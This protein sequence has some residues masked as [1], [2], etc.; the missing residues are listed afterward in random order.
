[1]RWDDPE[2][3][4]EW[5]EMDNYHVSDRDRVLPRLA[6]LDSPFHYAHGVA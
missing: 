5:P 2:L 6:E 1:V 4:V 3:A